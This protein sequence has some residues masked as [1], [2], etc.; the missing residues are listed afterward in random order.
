MRVADHY[1][2]LS[3]VEAKLICSHLRKFMTNTAE[4]P[5]PR[6]IFRDIAVQPPPTATFFTYGSCITISETIIVCK[7][8]FGHSARIYRYPSIVKL[9]FPS[10][11]T[12]NKRQHRPP[13]THVTH[14]IRSPASGFAD[15]TSR[16]SVVRSS[17]QVL[18]E[19]QKRRIGVGGHNHGSGVST[20]AMGER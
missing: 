1:M 6:F 10:W 8:S 9:S 12:P 20:Q 16:L 2:T 14:V 3:R 15:P 7:R 13:S 17:K 5:L 18:C 4:S 19:W 11:N